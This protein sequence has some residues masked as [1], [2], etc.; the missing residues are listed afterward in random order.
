MI[1]LKRLLSH[2]QR[3]YF[4]L[5]KFHKFIKPFYSPDTKIEVISFTIL[6]IIVSS[7]YLIA[8]TVELGSLGNNII[9]ILL[10]LSIVYTIAVF[11][12]HYEHETLEKEMHEI[13]AGIKDLK[14]HME[15]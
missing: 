12:I 11:Y 10:V 9:K 5:Y 13:E 4:S 7:F 8:T 6:I 3:T 2:K 14:E 15:N 1:E